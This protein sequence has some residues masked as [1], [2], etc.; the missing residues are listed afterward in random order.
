M[1][2]LT[3]A[4]RARKGW[5]EGGCLQPKRK[6]KTK[7]ERQNLKD[8][9][10][11]YSSPPRGEEVWLGGEPPACHSGLDPESRFYYRSIVDDKVGR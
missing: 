2:P 4:R 5:G 7:R 10:T 6:R 8:P 1:S 3:E 9:L 11:F